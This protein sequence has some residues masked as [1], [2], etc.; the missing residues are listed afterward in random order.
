MNLIDALAEV[1]HEVNRAYCHAIGDDSQVVWS[2]ATDDQRLSAKKGV[3]ALLSSNLNAEQLHGL[4]LEE[5]RRQGWTAGPVKDEIAKT[6]PCMVPYD[7]L[8]NEQKV[9]DHLSRAVV[10]TIQRQNGG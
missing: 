8:P 5:K 7:E 1:C 2:K 10:M 4:W 6:H 3:T 9:K